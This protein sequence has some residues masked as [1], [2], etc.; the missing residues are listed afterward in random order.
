M[1]KRITAAILS[2]CMMLF[3]L[4]V[5]A[6]ADQGTSESD[7]WD[8]SSAGDNS[9]KAYY[10]II[11]ENF[12]A[13][14]YVTG[15]G[16]MKNYSS[17][18]ASPWGGSGFCNNVVQINIG[19][20]VTNIGSN[21]FYS[22]TKVKEVFLPKSIV[23]IKGNSFPKGCEIV[24]N[25]RNYDIQWYNNEDFT[26]D[27]VN[28]T[29]ASANDSALKATYYAKWV[30]K[31]GT[32]S[33]GDDTSTDSTTPPDNGSST[34]PPTPSGGDNTNKGDKPTNDQPSKDD[35]G[36]NN[37]EQKPDETTP[38]KQKYDTSNLKFE[39]A[40]VTFDGKTHSL[41][42]TGVPE[43]VTVSYEGNNQS[44]AGTYIVTATFTGDDQHE[45][46]PNR[47][48]KLTI[49]KADQDISFGYET[50]KV[51]TTDKT[52]KNP[53]LG[54]KEQAV[55]TYTSSDE[56]VATVDKDGLVTIV[57]AGTAKITA[58]TAET[59]DYK[60]TSVSY[61]LTVA[62]T[63]DETDEEED[64]SVLTTEYP[65]GV[66]VSVPKEQGKV[67]S[68][69]V[70]VPEKVKRAVVTIPL[71]NVTYGTVAMNAKTGE[72]LRL[73]APTSD[74][75]AVEVDA[76]VSLILFDNS[77]MFADID[78]HWGEQYINFASA[79]NM[80]AGTSDTTFSANMSMTRGM[81]M[82]VIAKF[83]GVDVSGGSTWYERGM[84]W[85]KATGVSD[86]TNPMA[87]IT[88]EQLVCM[89]YNYSERPETTKSLSRFP[90]ANKVSS[91]AVD[92]MKWAVENGI[93]SGMGNG[94][95]TPQGNATRVQTATIMTKYC[96]YLLGV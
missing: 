55:V 12:D 36:E 28:P 2:F 27:S 37:G 52:T 73:C 51:P 81:M 1:K 15:D 24:A 48:A 41:Q 40:T 44:I 30:S 65:N 23:S 13:I 89:L 43:G 60:Q 93:I 21:A 35:N 49:E 61:T 94:T 38:Q 31:A 46:I 19:N 50:L 57:G 33:G 7:A 39:D 6:S 42:A 11:N 17:S 71:E 10:K 20:D 62:E 45:T 29:L 25:D 67:K 68:A 56:K 86:G 9:V 58:T 84:N 63:L 82:T 14:L 69:I 34:E 54:A 66:K 76:T 32:P 64:D 96:S 88:R 72:I 3:A 70:T 87:N 8:I 4:P 78:G 5:M 75:L 95:L 53:L 92:S 22:C 59:P 90:D 18:N 74:G 77:K 80:F 91:W 79:H 47:E 26:G 16:E 83:N 85:A